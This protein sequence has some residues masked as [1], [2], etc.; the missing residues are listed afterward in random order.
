[1]VLGNVY[2]DIAKG[3]IRGMNLGDRNSPGTFKSS[4]DS[5]LVTR[6]HTRRQWHTAARRNCGWT[7]GPGICTQG[8]QLQISRAT[9]L[10]NHNTS[11]KNLELIKK[12]KRFIECAD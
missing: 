11:V 1:M 9:V 10:L 2:W 12:M 5:R 7:P 6:F 8:V 4:G 3:A